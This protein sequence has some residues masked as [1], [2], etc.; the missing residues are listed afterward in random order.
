ML[1]WIL[2]LGLINNIGFANESLTHN[3]YDTYTFL[4]QASR[5]SQKLRESIK[6]L[7]TLG[8]NSKVRSRLIH[9]LVFTQFQ[10]IQFN[11]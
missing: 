9:A 7:R 6:N 11:K 8:I 5:K 1:D 2:P 4:L 10:R 3:H